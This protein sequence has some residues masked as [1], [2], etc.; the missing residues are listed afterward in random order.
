MFLQYLTYNAEV[1]NDVVVDGD[2]FHVVM[3]VR[4][5]LT[6]SA[7]KWKLLSTAQYFS[8]CNRLNSVLRWLPVNSKV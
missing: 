4:R 3:A 5:Q 8:T 2:Q 7:G 6:A 1:W